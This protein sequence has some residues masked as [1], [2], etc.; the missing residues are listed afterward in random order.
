MTCMKI[1]FRLLFLF[2]CTCGAHADNF[3]E[4]H[5]ENIQILRGFN[6]ELGSPKKTIITLEH[7]NRWKYGDLF[8]FADLQW[9]DDGDFTFYGEIT[10]RLSL[11]KISGKSFAFGAIKDVF[12][13]GNFEIPKNASARYLYGPS[14]D[15]DVPGF[16]FFKTYFF[17]RD[18]PDIAGTTHQVT[19]AWKR[20]VMLGETS[21]LLEGFAD[22]AGNEGTTYAANELFVPRFLFDV[23]GLVGLKPSRFFAG[24]EYTYW[25]NKAGL[26]GVTE[27]AA[28]AQL[29]WVF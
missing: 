10:P 26:R 15:W 8:V 25:R 12:L 20:T 14:V 11:S 17:L 29:K 9:P 24:M 16:T 4:W 28:Q 22:L 18:N 19:V 6:Y 23:G 21:L 13:A 3:I 27:S 7:A 2:F 1:I 5:S